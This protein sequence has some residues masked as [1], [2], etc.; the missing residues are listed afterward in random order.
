[1]GDG[2]EMAGDAISQATYYSLALATCSYYVLLTT[3][4][5]L[6][7]RGR[8]YLTTVT[9][10]PTSSYRRVVVVVVMRRP[11]SSYRHIYRERPPRPATQHRLQPY[12]LEAAT[13]CG[14]GCNPTWWRL[15]PYVVEA[16][17][18]RGGGCNPTRWRLQPYASL[19]MP[20]HAYASQVDR[21]ATENRVLRREQRQGK[22]DEGILLTS[23]SSGG[24]SRASVTR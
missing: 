6:L 19:C 18:L 23:G 15:Q 17:T 8:C 2:W 10:R 20:M 14:G 5:L 16:A 24:S 7:R 22:R 3:C 4:C 9:R 12:A 13:L 11:T 21:L 1:M